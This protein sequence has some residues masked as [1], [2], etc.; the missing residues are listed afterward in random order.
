MATPVSIVNLEPGGSWR[1][2]GNL[3]AGT[4]VGNSATARERFR[5]GSRCIAVNIKAKCSAVTS[6]PTIQVIP[7]LASCTEGHAIGSTL[8]AIDGATATALLTTE[9][10][11]A[12]TLKGETFFDVEV[13]SD[14]GDSA[15]ITYVD[16]YVTAQ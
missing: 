13:N 4:V 3:A 15:T 9:V 2:I 7:Q 5:V 16:V 11:H 10:A 8:D 12:Y 14:S 1:C 6:D